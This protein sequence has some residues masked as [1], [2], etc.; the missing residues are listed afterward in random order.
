MLL[1]LK[2]ML[3]YYKCYALTLK[4]DASGEKITIKLKTTENLR[5]SR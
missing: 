3:L 1:A 5:I 2:V 4:C